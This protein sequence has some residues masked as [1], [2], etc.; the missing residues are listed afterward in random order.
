MTFVL[1]AERLKSKYKCS[2]GDAF[3]LAT[4]I[5]LSGQFVTADHHELDEI[6]KHES[7]QFFWFR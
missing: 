2:L 7:I 3:G 5:V 6:E 4:T 1:E